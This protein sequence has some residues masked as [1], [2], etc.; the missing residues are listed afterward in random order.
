MWSPAGGW[1]NNTHPD[2]KRNTAIAFAGAGV[3]F[4]GLF[5]LS[6]KTERRYRLP[7]RYALAAK[8]GLCGCY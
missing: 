2:W 8:R 6:A 1:W 4:A 3:A 5:I 7:D